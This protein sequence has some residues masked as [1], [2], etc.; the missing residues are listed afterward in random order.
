MCEPMT[1]RGCDLRDFPHTPI[2]RS[3]LFGSSFHAKSNDSE[4][5][6]GVTL[7]LR[8][9]D[10]VPAGSLPDDEIELCR[11][12][13]LGRDV[14]T[15]RTLSDNALRGWVKCSD[16]R[17]YHPTVSEGVNTAYESKKAM[18]SRTLK[19]R[20]AALEKHLSVAANTD[21]RDR[22][23]TEISRL[24]LTLKNY[25]TDS[26]TRSVTDSVTESKYKEKEKEKE[27][28]KGKESNRE[29]HSVN[30]QAIDPVPVRVKTIQSIPASEIERVWSCFP[31]KVGKSAGFKAIRKAC[32]EVAKQEELDDPALAIPFLIEQ[33]T[34]HAKAVKSTE[35][36]FIP[37]PS[38]WL[39][40]G[41]YFDPDES[42]RTVE[43]PIGM[44]TSPIA[45]N[46][47]KLDREEVKAGKAAMLA[48]VMA[49]RRE[50]IQEAI[51]LVRKDRKDFNPDE[52]PRNWSGL[53]LVFVTG[54][55]DRLTT[56][57]LTIKKAAV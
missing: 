26:V 53:V 6:A 55:M 48:R 51:A 43:A 31:R 52:D 38:T 45:N 1:P 54:A 22:I 25:A 9:W 17:L 21:D 28:R 27:K 18:R 50:E 32:G 42:R 14:R 13:E 57:G 16:G 44:N 34:K 41:R 3:R 40:E 5:R 56:Q 11:L 30:G 33:V 20:I 39:N 15:W 23:S 4:W 19:A 8:S 35:M 2:F 29:K 47:P 37:H 36:R 12:A 49:C 46:A 7:W 24:S 10:Q